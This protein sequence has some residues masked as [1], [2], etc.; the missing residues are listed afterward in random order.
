MDRNERLRPAEE[1]QFVVHR[2]SRDMA[3]PDDLEREPPR[4]RLQRA[5]GPE[6]AALVIGDAIIDPVTIFFITVESL[7]RCMNCGEKVLL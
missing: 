3:R 7:F 6:P 5:P 2:T 1:E 4:D